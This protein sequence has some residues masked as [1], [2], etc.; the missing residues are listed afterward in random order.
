MKTMAM[1]RRILSRP[2]DKPKKLVLRP[3]KILLFFIVA[4]QLFVM[5]VVVTRARGRGL[6]E[7]VDV[8][9]LQQLPGDQ[10]KDL[11]VAASDSAKTTTLV[12]CYIST[13]NSDPSDSAAAFGT[14][15][16]TVRHDLSPLASS[17][18]VQLV[19][20]HYYDGGFI[21][22]V[23]K[24][25]IA[26]WGVQ[27]PDWKGVAPPKTDKDEVHEGK[28]LSNL[29]GTLSFAGGDPNCK[30]IFV[31]LVDNVRLDKEN[32]RP[33]ATVS[34]DSMQKVL[35]NLYMGYKDRQGQIK[36]LKQGDEQFL[37]KFPK[38]SRL[39]R[40]QVVNAFSMTL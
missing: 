16:I 32:S 38:A 9:A 14:L 10:K 19:Q 20:S 1:E 39:D 40:C 22:R 27:R 5:T 2:A 8:A 4:I 23:L 21:F 6:V 25:F 17:V 28:T 18:F 29:R 33:F 36:A 35:E 12:E 26:Q 7:R 11:V 24:H 30:H 15:E 3:G 31:N 37:K 13:P 34:E